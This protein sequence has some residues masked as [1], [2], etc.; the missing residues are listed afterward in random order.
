MCL[1]YRVFEVVL[2]KY[3]HGPD[4]YIGLLLC[5]CVLSE[6]IITIINELVIYD[7]IYIWYA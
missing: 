1:T 2:L 3:L 6:F 5:K 7:K 4:C